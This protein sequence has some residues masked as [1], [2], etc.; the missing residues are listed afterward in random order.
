MWNR[1]KENSEIV[2]SLVL[3]L[4]LVTCIDPFESFM[5]LLWE[6]TLVF[7]LIAVY[8]LYTGIVFRERAKDERERLHLAWAERSGFLVGT[9]LLVLFIILDIFRIS[10]E[11]ALIFVL[12]GMVLT[13]VIVLF[14]L[15]H[16]N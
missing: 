4:L 7:L 9:G 14:F 8:G 6:K 11:K 15:R 2:V 12:G 1:I 10:S 5:P 13:K 3:V 16:R